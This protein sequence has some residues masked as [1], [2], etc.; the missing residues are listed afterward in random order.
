MKQE[1]ER[2]ERPGKPEPL[3]VKVG[4][5]AAI[6]LE[7][8][9]TVLG[10]FFLGYLL[11]RYLSSSPWFMASFTI[12]ALIGAFIRLVRLLERFSGDDK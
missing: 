8:P 9:S 11:D 10:G 2:D 1:G 6:G 7:F 12:L 3:F 4:K 5:Y